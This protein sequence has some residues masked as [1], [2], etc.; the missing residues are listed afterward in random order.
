MLQGKNVRL[1]K[2]DKEDL[3]FFFE[4]WNSLNCYGEF[5]A[6]QPQISREEAQKRIER[7]DLSDNVGWTWF[8][9]EKKDGTKIGFIVH[10]TVQPSGHVEIGYALVPEEK[11]KGYGTEA[12]LIMTDYLFITKDIV[13][14]QATTDVRNIASQRILEKAGFQREGTLRKAGFIR[15]QLQDD[16]LYSILREEW[17]QPRILGSN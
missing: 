9:V 17:K 2:R 13:R 14:I 16:Y 5:E 7:T 6:I 11:G 4:F 15:G 1:R 12:L 8:V 10:F 3:D